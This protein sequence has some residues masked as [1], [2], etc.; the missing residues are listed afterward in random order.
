MDIFS[1]ES[2]RKASKG[3]ELQSNQPKKEIS[4][5]WQFLPAIGQGLDGITT[6]IALGQGAEEQNPLLKNKA[7]LIGTKAGLSLL[8]YYLVNKYK[9]DPKKA[10]TLSTILTL[11]GLVPTGLNI[12]TIRKQ[13]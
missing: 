13:K 4:K 7:V 9:K 8:G 6:S 2:I 12:N 11:G 5:K 3:I 1:P 10:K